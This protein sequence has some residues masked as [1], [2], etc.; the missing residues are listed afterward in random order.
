MSLTH[1]RTH[2]YV[3]TFFSCGKSQI[4][5]QTIRLVLMNRIFFV[6]LIIISHKTTNMFIYIYIYT[7]RK[8]S[9][10]LSYSPRIY[11]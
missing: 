5:E 6:Q 8:K 2:I 10:Y 4:H 9:G 7:I 11:I 1:T 3:F